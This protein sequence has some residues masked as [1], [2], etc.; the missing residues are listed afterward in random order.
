[1]YPL[2]GAVQAAGRAAIPMIGQLTKLLESYALT[3][4]LSNYCDG[5]WRPSIHAHGLRSIASRWHAESIFRVC[6]L[7]LII[8]LAIFGGRLV[9]KGVI[10]AWTALFAMLR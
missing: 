7:I 1:V 5:A 10:Y 2:K 9:A 6:Q 4:Q 8:T 3:G